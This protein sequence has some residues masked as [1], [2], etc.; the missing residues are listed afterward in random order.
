M[1]TAALGNLRYISKEMLMP[2]WLYIMLALNEVSR[3]FTAS[4]FFL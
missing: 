2:V 3:P 4:C 1:V